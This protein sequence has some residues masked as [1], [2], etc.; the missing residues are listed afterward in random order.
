MKNQKPFIVA[1]V[2]FVLYVF[3]LTPGLPPVDAGELIGCAVTFGIP[4]PTGYPLYL[5]L[6]RIVT[7]LPISPLLMLSLFSSIA[8]A[9]ATYWIARWFQD[10]FPH[11]LIPFVALLFPIANLVWES[12]IRPEVYALYVAIIA[13]VIWS[14]ARVWKGTER[15]EI[16]FVYVSA[17][18]LIAHLSSVYTLLPLWV[19]LLLR[20]ESRRVLLQPILLFVALL[21]I[22]LHLILP[23]REIYGKPPYSWGDFTTLDGWWRHVSGWQYR[24]WFFESSKAWWN[25]LSQ[26]FASLPKNT[27]WIGL[28]LMFIGIYQAFKGSKQQTI[29]LLATALFSIVM[30]SGYNIPDLEAY[31][32]P[33][34]IVFLWFSGVGTTY[35]LKKINNPFWLTS[36]FAMVWIVLAFVLAPRES[37]K[38]D[39]R[40]LVYARA[41]VKQLP[42]PSILITANWPNVAGPLSGLQAMGERKDVVV[43]D[44][45]LMRRS[46]YIRFLMRRYPNAI[47]GCEREFE[48]LIPALLKFERREPIS[49]QELERKYRAAIHSL[50]LK[51][52]PRTAVC[53]TEEI[54]T[55]Q[56]IAGSTLYR[57]PLLLFSRLLFSE[58]NYNAV[59]EGLEIDEL[60]EPPVDNPFDKQL[61]EA[62]AY[63][64]ALRAN[65]L[66][67]KP[68][69][70]EEAFTLIQLAKRIQPPV[71]GHA[72]VLIQLIEKEQGR[73]Q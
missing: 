66:F 23:I 55:P 3:T 60:F 8:M 22:T 15:S 48:D 2:T 65:Y 61:R 47:K 17:L 69:F 44:Q 31:Y 25:N 33:S 58:V 41:L 5:L 49:A 9:T 42:S 53:V 51:N 70:R 28:P 38:I 20:S 4:H 43:I 63:S 14:A 40:Q 19:G 24:I 26:F 12:A 21:P 29:W 62:V 27:A 59:P 50:I 73:K 30:V 11:P 46:W 71:G 34:L 7:I 45:E 6:S 72:D 64:F 67:K 56:S 39:L 52:I 1:I 16:I 35:L 57:I 10:E 68:D 37:R 54:N 32:I 36:I 13:M 18:A